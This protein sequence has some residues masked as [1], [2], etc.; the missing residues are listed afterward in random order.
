[1]SPPELCHEATLRGLRL[2]PWGDKLAV[3]PASRCPAEFAAT[4]RS[5]KD[6]ILCW[7]EAKRANMR[8][9]EA[10]WLQIAKKIL[11]GEFDDTDN[12][13]RESLTIGLRSIPHPACLRALEHLILPSSAG[14]II[15]PCN[16]LF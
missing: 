12:A 14:A 13:T 9:D 4:L 7:L 8:P 10:P 6:E 2:E 16:E 5:H 1:M 11:A 15:A 3:I